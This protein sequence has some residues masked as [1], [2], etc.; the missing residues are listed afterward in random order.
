MTP[1]PPGH[2]AGPRRQRDRVRGSSEGR[3]RASRLGASR[4][5]HRSV[6]TSRPCPLADPPARRTRLVGPS[7]RLSGRR[8]SAA[9]SVSRR[10]WSRPSAAGSADAGTA[11]SGSPGS[12]SSACWRSSGTASWDGVF[13]AIAA[14]ST[15]SPRGWVG[16]IEVADRDRG[17]A[18]AA[19]RVDAGPAVTPPAAAT[20]RAARSATERPRS[21]SADRLTPR[22]ITRS[23]SGHVPYRATDR[24]RPE[25]PH[26]PRPAPSPDRPGRRAS[27]AALTVGACQTAPAQPDLTDPEAILAAAAP[28]RPPPAA[29]H[30]DVD[31]R[32]AARPRPARHRAG[33]ADRPR[34]ARPRRADLDLADG[35]ARVTFAAPGLLGLAGE[36][37]VVDG[38]AY[39]KSTLTGPLYRR[40]PIGRTCRAAP[41]PRGRI[42]AHRS[43]VP[44]S[45]PPRPARRRPGQGRRRRRAAQRRATRVDDRADARGARR[46]RPASASADR[47][48]RPADPDPGPRATPTLDL[49]FRVD[50]DTTRLAGLTGDR[51]PR[52]RRP[53]TLTRRRDVLQVGRARDDHGPAGRPGRPRS[54]ARRC[55]RATAPMR[56]ADLEWRGESHLP[57]PPRRPDPRRGRRR[58]PARPFA[59]VA[60]A[61]RRSPTSPSGCATPPA[62]RPR[63]RPRRRP[64]R[65]TPPPSPRAAR[66]ARPRSSRRSTPSRRAP[67]RRRRARCS[68]WPARARARPASWPTGSPT[69]SASRACRRGGSWPSRSRTRPRP[70]L[71]ERIISLVGEGGRDVQAGTFHAL[72]ARVLRQDGE[73]IGIS[74]RFVIYDTDDQQALMKQ[75]LREE[76]LP[77]TGEFR[78]SA[79]LGAISRAKNEMLDPTFLS[80]ERGE[81]P[82]AARSPASRRATRSGSR[83][84]RALDFDDLLL[85]AVRLFDEA[86]DVLAKYQERWRYLHV[87]EYQDTNRAQ[88]LW[89]KALADEVRQ[90]RRRRRRRPVDLLVARRGPAQ[91]PRLRA[92]LADGRGREARAQLPLDP[93]HPRRRPR[94]RV[95]QHARA[96][97][98]SSGPRTRAA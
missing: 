78:P 73:A 50:K 96:R 71:R 58:P 68:S 21:P 1:R 9:R 24:L 6:G 56:A 55:R 70:E 38:T 72:C 13:T 43:K 92:R 48:P 2:R 95:A 14:R 63:S 80:R 34:P 27:L 65:R 81:P 8:R 77:L 35:D 33:A 12:S 29:V 98:R 53:A 46:A 83:R 84:A 7:S 97:T 79:V 87:D 30:V 5:A 59:D 93:A 40:P 41:A 4:S 89:V 19:A 36:L 64:R 25:E 3:T 26:V 85:E 32:W 16:G 91:H 31:R 10:A 94:R 62:A 17:P 22:G 74:R 75:I 54:A 66:N 37:I 61:T 76:D 49:T 90:P 67:S 60:D 82:R 57:S 51:G 86:P 69:W 39:V 52:R 42:P 88:Y 20:S 11:A 45:R 23:L 15:T 28:R 47:S 18:T 44:V